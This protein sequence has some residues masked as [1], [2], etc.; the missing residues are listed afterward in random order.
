MNPTDS[1]K[2]FDEQFQNQIAERKLM[3]NP[4]EVVALPH[5]HGRV[6]DFGCGLGNLTIEAARRGCSVDALDASLAAIDHIRAIAK[7]EALAVRATKA[8]L[9]TYEI[10]DIY[11]TA[12]CI[13]LLMFFDCPTAFHQ[14]KAMQDHVRPGGVAVV[15]VLTEGTTYMDMFAPEGHCLFKQNDLRERFSDW[16]ILHYE[17]QGFDA[18]A[19]TRKVFATAIARKPNGTS[20]GPDHG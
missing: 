14:L 2:F 11:D 7:Q 12:V 10:T 20:K 4:F 3:L 13:G 19:N 6:L 15:N 5:V 1:V 8:D 18:P 9:R 17:V 16:E